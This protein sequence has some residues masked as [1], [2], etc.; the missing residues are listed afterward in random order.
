MGGIPYKG[1]G[2]S[3]I[4]RIEAVRNL[5]TGNYGAVPE[6]IARSRVNNIAAATCAGIAMESVA[7]IAAGMSASIVGI[8]EA[9][10]LTASAGALGAGMC[11]VASDNVITQGEM[12]IKPFTDNV[13]NVAGHISNS[14]L[15]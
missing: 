4:N 2:A 6:N 15:K 1:W 12:L 14:M 11:Y 7:P 3:L 13:A 8:P 5:L 10:L 9:A